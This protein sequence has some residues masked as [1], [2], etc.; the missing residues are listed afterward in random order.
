[1]SPVDERHRIGSLLYLSGVLHEVL[2]LKKTAEKEWSDLAIFSEVFSLFDENV[3]DDKTADLLTKIRNRAAFHFDPTLAQ[4]TLPRL[5]AEPF[6]FITA[7]GRDPMNANYELADIITF[8]F[9]FDAPADVDMLSK[10]LGVF[11]PKL[12][13]LLRDFV[14]R[15]DNLLLRR[16]VARGFRIVERPSGYFRAERESDDQASD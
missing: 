1:M 9:I 12:D 6:T 10:K 7:T 14:K 5:P 15:T 2:E 8:G 4:R 11:R 16:L 3:V 13:S